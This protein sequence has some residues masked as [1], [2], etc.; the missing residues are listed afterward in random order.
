M[1][2]KVKRKPNTKLDLIDHLNVGYRVQNI[3]N[4]KF[5]INHRPWDSYSTKGDMLL[6]PFLEHIYVITGV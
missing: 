5:E 6:L 1:H 4:K 3:F 2:R